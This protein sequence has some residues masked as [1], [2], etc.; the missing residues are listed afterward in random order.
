MSLTQL[1]RV[2]GV[3]ALG[4]SAATPGARPHDMSAENH[5]AAAK[6]HQ[7]ASEEHAADYNP[8]ASEARERCAVSPKTVRA[9]SNTDA[10]WTSVRNPTAVHAR[11]A[12]EHR[13]HAADHRAAS[14]AL[15]DAEALSCAGLGSG[16]RDISPFARRDDIAG[17]EP[18][19]EPNNNLKIPGTRTVGAIVT[20]RAVQG[21]TA[22]WLQRIVDCH[23][24]RNSA[25]GHAVPEMPYCPLV[26]KGVSATVSSAGGG[27][28]I[29]IRAEDEAGAREVLARAE[30]LTK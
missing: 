9:T 17:V 27:F 21:M 7:Q 15:R 26:P 11:Q 3:L 2:F 12:A 4:C 14:G 20:F 13:R 10:C 5:E 28:R 18:L 8:D 1:T 16:D 19:K 23:I 30:R 6:T 24:A 22:E 29:S 25:L